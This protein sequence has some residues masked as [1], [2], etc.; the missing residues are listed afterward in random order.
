MPATRP[1]GEFVVFTFTT[2]HDALTAEEL[3]KAAGLDVV[4]IPAP[5]SPTAKC[6]LAM[7]LP[8]SQALPAE[9]AMAAGGVTHAGAVEG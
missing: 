8:A 3:L 4:P 5:S 7:R 9:E 6:G 2:T 1:E